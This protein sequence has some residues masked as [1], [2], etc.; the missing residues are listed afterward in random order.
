MD[1]DSHKEKLFQEF[2]PIST[3]EWEKKIKEDLKGA[4]YE[5]KLIWKTEE[6][7]DV[8]PYYRS[9]DLRELGYLNTVPGEFPYTRGNRIGDNNWCIRQDIREE[10]IGEA[11]RIAREA[12]QRGADAIGFP[13]KEIASHKQMNQLLEGIDISKTGIHFLSSRSYP[14]TLELFNYEINHRK[15]DGRTI[16]GSLNFDPVS[17]LLLHG[18]FWVS[19]ENNMDEAEY[20]VNTIRKKIPGF[21]AITV[22]GQLFGNSGSTL[23]QE[24]AFSLASANE[25]LAGLTE[26]GIAVDEITPRIQFSFGIG[27]V[28]FLEIAKLR[29]ARLLW[30]FLVDQ[31]KPARKESAR[32]FIHATTS[33]WNKTV[34]DPYVNMLRTTT[35]GMAGAIGNADSMSILPFDSAWRGADD[36]SRRIALNQQLILKEEANLNQVA[37]PSAGSY[38][39]ENLTHSVAAHAWDLFKTIEGKGGMIRCIREGFIQDEIEKSS[40][41]K[42]V[43]IARRNT[44]LIG[45]NQYPNLSETLPETESASSEAPA[46]PE[47]KSIYRK[48]R[49]TRGSEAFEKLRMATDRFVAQGNKR[50]SVFLLETGNLAMRKARAM[51]VT[52]FFGCS[53]Y[54]ILNP[55]GFDNP[56]EGATAAIESGARLVVICN[57]D[58]EYPIVAPA[59]VAGIKRIKPDAILIVAGYPKETADGL[60]SAGI[61]DFIH[62]RSNLL[63]TLKKYQEIMGIPD[64][65]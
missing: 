52:N 44:V 4:D 7:F 13:V 15:L 1:I 9:G 42:D 31:Y 35:E 48:L 46:E 65:R 22:N 64:Q 14:L 10:A 61:D 37:D 47:K 41:K 53:G 63:D 55:T 25:Y 33:L 6:G 29:A 50:P 20:L 18:D 40:K 62:I 54:E 12:V 28:Y 16:N 36:F 30:A 24:L 8:R 39:I 2:P 49:P 3:S 60:T 21:R 27:S 51:F 17:Y 5:K 45:T 57:S 32:M 11:N 56:E 19:A 58:E 43:D 34:Y 26:K 23:V 38:F 59:I